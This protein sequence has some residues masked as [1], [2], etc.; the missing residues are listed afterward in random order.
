[1]LRRFRRCVGVVFGVG[2][3]I[4]ISCGPALS[5]TLPEALKSAY[6]HNPK[7]Q[8]ERATLRATDEEVAR[9]KSGWRP[10]LSTS[11]DVAYA[12]SS[13]DPMDPSDGSGRPYG[14][15]INASQ[16]IFTGFRTR[17][18]VLEAEAN[19]K[20]GREDLRSVEIETLLAAAT[21]Y[22]DVYR[23]QQIV[24]YR[25]SNLRSLNLIFNSIKRQQRFGEATRAE[26]AQSTARLAR[27]RAS[28]SA[29][30]SQLK[31]DQAEF[32]RIVGERPGVLT[33]ARAPRRSLPR[34]LSIARE[35]GENESPL[36]RA[37]V[38][39][40]K[41]AGYVVAKVRGELLPSV[42]LEASYSDR[43]D[44]TPLINHSDAA[45]VTGQVTVPLYQGGEVWAR[46]RQ[47]THRR[48]K[49]LFDVNDA[50]RQ[51][52]STIRAAWARLKSARDQ[53]KEARAQ[54]AANKVAVTGTKE[55]Y[56]QGQISLREVLDTQEDLNESQV[57]LAQANRDVTEAGFSLLAS[58]GQL[59]IDRLHLIAN[60]YDPEE[61]YESVK[62]KWFGLTIR[63]ADGRVERPQ[64]PN[65][66]RRILTV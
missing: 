44:S 11:A 60:P 31:I 10:S 33:N 56:Q 20:A 6:R 57:A 37:A 39:R 51:V 53:L 19:V 52:E 64:H 5:Q 29:A 48:Q 8:G 36:L 38:Y 54:V 41:A 17:N 63:Y 9:A 4:I 30:Q 14:Y 2:V 28:L 49:T 12:K 40:N 61:H 62:N 59:Q 21:A 7:L 26:V 35:I 23:D 15:S 45:R 22:T 13:T 50:R 27:A 42:S 43:F 47:A 3:A 66:Q 18:A 24:Q 32:Q 34:S 65:Q 16:P 1:M 58:T 46:V 25:R 55:S